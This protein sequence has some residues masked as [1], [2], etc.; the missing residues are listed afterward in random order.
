MARDYLKVEYD[1]GRRPM[2][3]YPEMLA[4]HIA[5][6]AGIRPGDALLEVGS[7]R[8]EVAKGFVG[9]GV[10]VTAVDSAPSA[11]EYA[12]QAGAE[13]IQATIGS[14][15]PIPV[16]PGSQDFVFSKSFVEHLREPL[17]FLE[18]C[19]ELLK[20]RGMIICLTPDWEANIRIFFDDVTHVTPF[21]RATMRQA[22][23]LAGYEHID[24]FRFRQLPITWRNPLVN[25]A[26]ATI[27]PFVPARTTNKFFR[28]SRELMLCGMGRLA[29]NDNGFGHE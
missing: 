10:H 16:P 3:T 23:E 18:K 5:K 6:L 7:G 9:L 4:G 19:R 22:L 2:T 26:S 1:K 28:W 12:R 11:A 17:P 24:V 27:A 21:S 25:L 13:F 15:D 14:D 20:P 8:A 29:T